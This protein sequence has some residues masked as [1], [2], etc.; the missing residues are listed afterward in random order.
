MA[1]SMKEGT[2]PMTVLH[3][4][5]QIQ[6]LAYRICKE[7]GKNIWLCDLKTVYL[8]T[9][10]FISYRKLLVRAYDDNST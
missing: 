5:L 9:S 3:I 4:V 6:T 2:D 7:R 10:C 1:F 8:L